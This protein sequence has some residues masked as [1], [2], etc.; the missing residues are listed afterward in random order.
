MRSHTLRVHMADY[1]AIS[2]GH[3]TLHGC[4]DRNFTI[5]DHVELLR[6]IGV[7]WDDI[8]PEAPILEM[9]IAQVCRGVVGLLPGYVV[10][11][12]RKVAEERRAA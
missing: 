11:E 10:L 5:G 9:R 8:D 12:L 6:Y 1:D 4:R 2:S 7:G 3:N